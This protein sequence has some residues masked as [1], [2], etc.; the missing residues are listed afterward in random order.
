MSC[1]QYSSIFILNKYIAMRDFKQSAFV[2]VLPAVTNRKKNNNFSEQCKLVELS[3]NAVC[4]LYC[5][6]TTVINV[7]TTDLL[8]PSAAR[9]HTILDY[10]VVSPES[11]RP[12]LSRDLC[13]V[14]ISIL[15]LSVRMYVCM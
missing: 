11:T 5:S 13:I 8:L 6:V 2:S 7:D 12:S 14:E 1:L 3:S 9:Q 4:K 10:A 15:C